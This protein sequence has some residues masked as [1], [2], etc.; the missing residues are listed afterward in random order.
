MN[1][2]MIM[3]VGAGL[4]ELVK[5]LRHLPMIGKEMNKMID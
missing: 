3:E 4:T 5:V 1:M 2:M